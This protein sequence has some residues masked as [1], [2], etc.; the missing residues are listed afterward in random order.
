MFQNIICKSNRLK[1]L[2]VDPKL[3]L[4]LLFDAIRF[5]YVYLPICPKL[6]K[7]FSINGITYIFEKRQ[8]AILIE[9]KKFDIIELGQIPPEIKLEFK[10]VKIKK[11]D[12]I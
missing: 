5:D 7:D 1:V 10:T 8:F 4:T 3:I 11:E 6:P 9:S 12:V 2:Y